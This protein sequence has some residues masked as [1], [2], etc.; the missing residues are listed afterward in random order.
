MNTRN[1]E[2]RCG[3]C[4]HALGRGPSKRTGL[5]IPNLV[6]RLNPKNVPQ[7][8]GLVVTGE[9]FLCIRCLE[10]NTNEL[11]KIHHRDS[12]HTAERKIN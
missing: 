6:I 7:L 4:L 1:F 5:H 3:L 8:R 2:N 11:I 12:I 9:V 10:I